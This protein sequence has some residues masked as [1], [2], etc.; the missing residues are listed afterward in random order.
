MDPL[1]RRP[2]PIR[3]KEK[4]FNEWAA[5][6]QH[7]DEIGRELKMQQLHENKES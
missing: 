1:G 6:L 4:I 7:Q 2:L 5:V 3:P